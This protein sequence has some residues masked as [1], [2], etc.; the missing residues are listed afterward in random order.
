MPAPGR[1]IALRLPSALVSLSVAVAPASSAAE[2]PS[3]ADAAAAQALFDEAR[4]A[5][6]RGAVAEACSK[7]DASQRLEPAAG[8]L[9]HLADCYE[10]LG[11]VASAWV[12]FRD[13]AAAARRDGRSDWARIGE[14]RAELLEVRLPRLAVDVDAGPVAPPTVTVS[15]NALPPAAWGTM[16]PVDPGPVVV[17]AAAPGCVFA[18]VEVTMAERERRRVALPVPRCAAERG[19][20]P[21]P[22]APPTATASAAP[23]G[24]APGTARTPLTVGLAA[25]SAVAAGVAVGFGVDALSKDREAE[26]LC[27]ESP[28]CADARA[29]ELTDAA[30]TSATVTNVA[31]VTA[32]AFAVGAVVTWLA[33]PKASP[34]VALAPGALGLRY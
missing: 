24:H 4:A 3:A 2:A 5:L 23:P 15:G 14:G 11:R 18:R 6:D 31:I 12:T 32:A 21:S 10:R 9:L 22:L 28:R 20:A 30:K 29:V 33:W 27:P 16:L 8:T 19:A 34:R 1:R 13:A 17:A 7:L 26:R 25:A